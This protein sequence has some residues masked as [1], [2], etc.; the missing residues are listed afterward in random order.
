MD[1]AAFHIVYVDKRVSKKLDGAYLGDEA[2]TGQPISE[3]IAFQRTLSTACLDR[4]SSECAEVRENLSNL[5]ASFD[6]VHMCTS[7]DSCLAKLSQFGSD[8]IDFEPILVI[9][10]ASMAIETQGS[11]MR[12]VPR[13]TRPPSV[14]QSSSRRSMVST[15]MSDPMPIHDVNLLQFISSQISKSEL[16]RAIVPIVFV[17][18]TQPPHGDRG[19]PNTVHPALSHQFFKYLEDGATDV[20]FSPLAHDCIRCIMSNVYRV[21]KDESAFKAAAQEAKKTRK[22]SWVGIDDRKPYAYLR[23]EMYVDRTPWSFYGCLLTHAEQGF[24]SNDGNLLSGSRSA[25]GRTSVSSRLDAL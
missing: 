7:K 21:R 19:K 10:E 24:R 14:P 2:A 12:A 17:P 25:S 5:V 23:E 9:L 13:E 8:R 15:T 6:G 18:S 3:D 1:H 4:L 11:E 16:S 20:L 22:R